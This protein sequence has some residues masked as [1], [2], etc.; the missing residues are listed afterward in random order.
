MAALLV[1]SPS[2]PPKLTSRNAWVVKKVRDKDFD[3]IFEPIEQNPSLVWETNSRGWTCLHI[4]CA[5]TIPQRWWEWLLHQACAGHD[6]L[7]L[8]QTENG[9]TPIDLY[10]RKN[11]FPYVWQDRGQKESAKELLDAI[12]TIAKSKPLLDQLRLCIIHGKINNSNNNNGDHHEIIQRVYAFW[13]RLECLVTVAHYGRLNIVCRQKLRTELVLAL[14]NLSWCPQAVADLAV[15]LFPQHFNHPHGYHALE[16]WAATKSSFERYPQGDCGSL[17]VLCEYYYRSAPTTPPTTSPLNVAL[18][19]GKR[20][21]EIKPLFE[22]FP[23]TILER[24]E[25][26]NLPVFCLPAVVPMD[27]HQVEMTARWGG[28]QTGIWHYLSQREKEKELVKAREMVDRERLETIY[29][30]LRRN[31]SAV[32]LA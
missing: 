32:S 14:A 6:K 29:Q 15:R 5:S 24:D 22:T 4:A 12:A 11:L 13:Q 27:E 30:L 25:L 17:R 8:A 7:R 9:Q 31:P 19:M 3:D 28:Q 1:S 23:D 18:Q 16:I 20:W 26:T 21:S 2:P 10:F